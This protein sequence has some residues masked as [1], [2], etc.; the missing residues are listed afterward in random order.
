[1]RKTF[2]QH[3]WPRDHQAAGQECLKGGLWTREGRHWAEHPLSTST[4]ADHNTARQTAVT[5]KATLAA[6]TLLILAL[7]WT[8]EAVQV[9]VSASPAVDNYTFYSLDEGVTLFIHMYCWFESRNITAALCTVKDY[10]HL[11]L[12]FYCHSI[13]NKATLKKWSPSLSC[14]Y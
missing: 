4:T 5:M 6:I 1:M 14:I 9:E 12:I 13:S 7:N 11:P 8:T 3:L 2:L 10:K